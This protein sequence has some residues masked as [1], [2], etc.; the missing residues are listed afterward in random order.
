MYTYTPD[1]RNVDP[2]KAST[3]NDATQMFAGKSEKNNLVC[4]RINILIAPKEENI[5]IINK[6]NIT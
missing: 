5:V 1:W 2:W 3:M 6:L 4:G